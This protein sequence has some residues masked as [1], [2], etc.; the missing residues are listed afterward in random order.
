[1]AVAVALAVAV[2]RGVAVT[3]AVRVT[4]R[5]KMFLNHIQKKILINVW[6]Y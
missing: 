6:D 4:G 5:T 3:V 1:M 2:S